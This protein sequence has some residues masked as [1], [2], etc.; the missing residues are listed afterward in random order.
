MIAFRPALF[1]VLNRL[2]GLKRVI[3]GA[4]RYLL[5]EVLV[6]SNYTPLPRDQ[7]YSEG[8]RLRNSWQDPAL[9]SRQLQF[10]NQQLRE[11]RAGARVDVFDVFV[12]SLRYLLS[13]LPMDSTLLEIGC[14]S[15]YYSEVIEIAG[16]PVKYSGCDYSEAFVRL[17]KKR[18]PSL[19]FTVADATALGYP[20]NCFDV[21]VSGSCLLHIPDYAKGIEE[22]VRVARHYAIFHRTPVFWGQD[23]QWYRKLAYGI[24]TVEIHF[25]EA[26]FLALL[27]R[28]GL[29][30][31]ATYTL[32]EEYMNAT[33]SQGRAWRT[34]VC[35]KIR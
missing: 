19:H 29:E 17:A 23:E 9:P 32:N 15:G 24:E 11:Y 6:S 31:I 7:A 4:R 26:K 12:E 8:Y 27:Q 35:K 30:L 3:R 13:D 22:T 18:Y 25:N 16:L 20:D 28:N 34:Y 5:R 14:S 1:A 10:V 2:P 33:G 21:A